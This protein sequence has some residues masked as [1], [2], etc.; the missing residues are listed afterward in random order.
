MTRDTATGERA[1]AAAR[2]RID[3][4]DDLL[5]RRD[6]LKMRSEALRHQLSF[7]ANRTKPVFRAADRMAS[8]MDWVKAHPG[9]VAVVAAALLGAIAA[10]PRAFVRVGSR[11]LATWQIA[12]RAQPVVR[13]FMRRG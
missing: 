10:R 6:Q 11:A 13:A 8:G 7:Q 1:P 9:L 2:K 5:A 4:D 12:Q 3:V